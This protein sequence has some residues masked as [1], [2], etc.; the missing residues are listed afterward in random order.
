MQFNKA[1]IAVMQQRL[2]GSA[3][4]ILNFIAA[5]NLHGALMTTLIVGAGAEGTGA[6]GVYFPQE[7]SEGPDV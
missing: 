7:N 5:Q 6:P 2:F 4:H 3:D 1:Q